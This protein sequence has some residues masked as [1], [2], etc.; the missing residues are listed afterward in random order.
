MSPNRGNGMEEDINLRKEK[1]LIYSKIQGRY[2]LG[3]RDLM[4]IRNGM[5]KEEEIVE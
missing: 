2:F 1:M 3:P 5:N 4:V